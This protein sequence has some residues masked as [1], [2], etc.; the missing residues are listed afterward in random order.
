METH[1]IAVRYEIIREGR[2]NQKNAGVWGQSCWRND[3]GW[4][5][6]VA[7]VLSV[8]V[9]ERDRIRH[10]I[11][12]HLAKTHLFIKTVRCVIAINGSE[13]DRFHLIGTRMLQENRHQPRSYTTVFTAVGLFHEHLAERADAAPHILERNSAYQPIIIEGEPEIPAASLI[14]AADITQIGLLGG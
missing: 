7:V 14:E 3:G 11:P 2:A 12:R 10:F 9:H 4:L 5:Q 8:D 1:A 13:I 6:R